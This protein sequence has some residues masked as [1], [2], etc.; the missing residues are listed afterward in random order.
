MS[1]P[2]VESGWAVLQGFAMKP[3]RYPTITVYGDR[4][5]ADEEA[6][7]DEAETIVVPTLFVRAEKKDEGEGE[8]VR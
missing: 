5:K 4:A 8:C 7:R 3:D 2:T 6:K 1:K